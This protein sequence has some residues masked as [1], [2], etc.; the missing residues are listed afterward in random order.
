MDVIDQGTDVAW[1]NAGDVDARGI[2]CTSGGGVAQLFDERHAGQTRM[3]QCGE[4]AVAAADWIACFDLRRNH[5]EAR[6]K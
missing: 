5:A 2:R 3:G 4:V 1:G 6:L